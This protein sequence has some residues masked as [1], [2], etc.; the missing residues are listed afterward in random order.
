MLSDRS[1]AIIQTLTLEMLPEKL[2]LEVYCGNFATRRWY[3]LYPVG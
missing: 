3:N 2:Q 1:G